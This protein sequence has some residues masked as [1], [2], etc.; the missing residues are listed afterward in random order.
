MEIEIKHITIIFTS[1]LLKNFIK[2]QTLTF[3]SNVTFKLQNS[4]DQ[5]TDPNDLKLF[6]LMTVDPLRLKVYFHLCKNYVHTGWIT[7]LF[8]HDFLINTK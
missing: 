5:I 6:I 7:Y 8:E 2:K 4:W 1:C 3:R